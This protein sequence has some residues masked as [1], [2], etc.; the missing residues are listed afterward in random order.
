MMKLPPIF[1]QTKRRAATSGKTK[2]G[3]NSKRAKSRGGDGDVKLN[4]K[5][6]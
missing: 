2:S 3:G 5:W 1:K 6:R 4:D